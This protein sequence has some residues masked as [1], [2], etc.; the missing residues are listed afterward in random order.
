MTRESEKMPL[1]DKNGNLVHFDKA[2]VKA[3]VDSGL[4]FVESPKPIPSLR[5]KYR[6][7]IARG[8]RRENAGIAA[9]RGVKNEIETARHM[10]KLA[11]LKDE[12]AVLDQLTDEE[13]STDA[14]RKRLAN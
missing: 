2:E 4:Y 7:A 1:Y 10:S 8:I 13:L 5:E 6:A 11:R 14:A 3:R 9:A 12:R